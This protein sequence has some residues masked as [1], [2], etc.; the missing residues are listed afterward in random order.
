MRE[1]VGR[2]DRLIRVVVGSA[3]AFGGLRGLGAQTLGPAAL[4]AAGALVLES[5]L[6][7]VCPVN[8]LLGIDTRRDEPFQRLLPPSSLQ[9]AALPSV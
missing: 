1:N 2:T 9:A 8:H 5:A 6:T 4:L 7:R 3:L